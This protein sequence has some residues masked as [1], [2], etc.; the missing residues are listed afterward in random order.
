M[1]SSY[2]KLT[3]ILI[4]GD[5]YRIERDFFEW[6]DFLNGWQWLYMVQYVVK[7]SLML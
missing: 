6:L 5:H 1:L 4:G 3:G 2:V 7:N